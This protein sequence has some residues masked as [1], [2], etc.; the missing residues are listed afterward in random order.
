ML[1][2]YKV[3]NFRSEWNIMKHLITNQCPEKLN[4][5]AFD[6]NR[7]ESTYIEEKQV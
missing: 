1:E 4:K 3:L 7:I 6:I 5:F 2:F